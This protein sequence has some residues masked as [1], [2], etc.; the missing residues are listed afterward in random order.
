MNFSQEIFNSGNFFKKIK[1]RE[2]VIAKKKLLDSL[3]KNSFGFLEDLYD[4]DFSLIKKSVKKFKKY[5]DILFLGTG[6][7][8]LGG[9]TLVEISNYLNSDKNLPRIHFFENIEKNTFL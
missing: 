7:S 8:S 4:K 6:G 2:F 5:N 1:S 3:K 9:K